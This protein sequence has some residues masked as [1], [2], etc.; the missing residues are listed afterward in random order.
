M[1][2]WIPLKIVLITG[3]FMLIQYFIPR[4]ESEFLYEYA[5]DFT[6]IIGIFAL[7]LGIISLVRV[8]ID[9][10]RRKAVGW[11]Y[12][13]VVLI[14]LIVMLFFGWWPFRVGNVGDDPSAAVVADVD[15]DQD[16]DLIVANKATNNISIFKNRGNSLFISA[17][18]YKAG[19]APSDLTTFDIDGDNDQDIAVVNSES[20][21]VSL[22]RNVS[23]PDDFTPVKKQ[24]SPETRIYEITNAGKPRLDKP[25]AYAVGDNPV[26]I[27]AGDL[28]GDGAIND[29][30]VANHGSD[31][32]SLLL[33]D[34]QGNLR[35]ATTLPAGQ[36]P[37]DIYVADMNA[38]LI[39][40]IIVSN[41][42]SRNLMVLFGQGAGGFQP[43]ETVQLASGVPTSMVTGDFDDNGYIDLAVCA[44]REGSREGI[45]YLLKSDSTGIFATQD[46]FETGPMP[47]SIHATDFNQDGSRDLAIACRD[48]NTV[49]IHHNDGA[50]NFSEYS[51]N[52]AGREPVF[53]T[54]GILDV[55]KDK[56]AI[57]VANHLSN[58]IVTLS[59][60]NGFD[61]EPGVSLQS[62]DILF[63]GGS[64][65]NYFFVKL[66]DH[67]MIPIQAT[68][69]S[70]LAFYIASAA[71]RAFRARTLLSSILLVAAVLIMIRFVPLGP[72]SDIVN[73][74][75]SWILKVPNMAAKRA[76]FIGIGLGMVATAIKILLG[77]ERGYLGRD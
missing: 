52:F 9:K 68:M 19:K 32:I 44:Y 23:E 47:V 50:G 73:D 12:S 43:A 17:Y 66:F 70:L 62:G 71:Y 25:V 1:K 22:L 36:K 46:N 14:G 38:D 2:Q 42:E 58:N 53:V 59:N 34:G 7:A 27:A 74:L 31:N 6:I 45:L 77:V 65:T 16:S 72:I 61:F 39:N 35:E 41:Q 48:A 28:N 67:V 60:R 30:V 57:V 51:Q 21:D 49:R 8:S 75:S 18:I 29:L 69:F 40:D 3:L 76:I 54:A 55:E 37:N 11:I 24:I 4:E 26:A 10:I 63:L 20:G 15:F 56:P 33:N 13:Y 64:L 5:L